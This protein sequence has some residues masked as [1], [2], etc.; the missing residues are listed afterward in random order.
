MRGRPGALCRTSFPLCYRFCS[1]TQ[2]APGHG[3]KTVARRF[4]KTLPSTVLVD[5]T[6]SIAARVAVFDVR[7]ASRQLRARA[8]RCS[9]RAAS[10]CASPICRRGFATSATAW[11][12]HGIGRGDRVASVLPHGPETA[13]CFL[14][15]ASCAIHV[16]LN[17]EYSEAEFTQ[18]LTQLRS[19]AH[20]PRGGCGCASAPLQRWE[21]R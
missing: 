11:R 2:L 3:A 19:C 5:D 18:Y 7:S 13:V 17:P 12:S 10:R 16:P 9:S 1:A 8:R 15:V 14:G 4:A 20:R 6:P 21:F